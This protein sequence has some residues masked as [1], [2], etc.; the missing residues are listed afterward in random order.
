MMACCAA[1]LTPI[2]TYFVA[3]GTASGLNE[4]LAVFAP[5]LLCVGAHLLL[6]R[7]VGAL[8]HGHGAKQ[9]NAAEAASPQ[10]REVTEN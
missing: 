5:L 6:H 2:V 3:G 8:C 9:D 7:F 10:V 1:M 4:N